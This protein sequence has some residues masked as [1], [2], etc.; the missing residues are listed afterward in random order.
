MSNNWPQNILMWLVLKKSH[1]WNHTTYSFLFE[2]PQS[3]VHVSKII[4]T[5]NFLYGLSYLNDFSTNQ[6]LLT[7]LVAFSHPCELK[8]KLTKHQHEKP[9]SCLSVGSFQS[10]HNDSSN[11]FV[12][13]PFPLSIIRK[14]LWHESIFSLAHFCLFMVR[15]KRR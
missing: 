13:K 10:L 14:G 8:A 9:Y 12:T 4:I 11:S 1:P 7:V 2:W 5:T 15:R 6:I 3:L